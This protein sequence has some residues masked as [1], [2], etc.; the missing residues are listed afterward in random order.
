[1]ARE[2]MMMAREGMMMANWMDGVK[3][4]E[5]GIGVDYAVGVEV[6]GEIG[7]EV[8][9]EVVSLKKKC[10]SSFKAVDSAEKLRADYEECFV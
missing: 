7:V 5:V 2:G 3:V 9:G 6:E 8:E 10:K 4:G 1:M